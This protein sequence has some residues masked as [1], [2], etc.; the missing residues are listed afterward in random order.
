MVFTSVYYFLFFISYVLFLNFIKSGYRLH[1]VVVGSLIFYGWGNPSIILVPIILSAI[2]F[3]GGKWI[4]EVEEGLVIRNRLLGLVVLLLIP[5][6]YFKY[7]NFLYNE[8][9]VPIVGASTISFD[10][11]LPLGISFMTFTIVSYVVDVHKKGF[12]PFNHFS[13]FLPISFIF[14]D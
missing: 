14:L 4:A 5:L 10:V 2:A 11:V 9:I 6:T 1:L 13:T 7:K 8:I 12:L 3:W